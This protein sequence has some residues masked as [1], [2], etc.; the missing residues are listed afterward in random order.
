MSY[1][2]YPVISVRLA[3]AK[4]SKRKQYVLLSSSC[5][6]F[7]GRVDKKENITVRTMYVTCALGFGRCAEILSI[8][9]IVNEPASFI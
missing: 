9:D 3:R 1:H 2:T 6:A 8:K 7:I 4:R 5:T